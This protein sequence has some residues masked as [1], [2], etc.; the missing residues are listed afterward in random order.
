M[1]H[2]VHPARAAMVLR[3]AEEQGRWDDR[4]LNQSEREALNPKGQMFGGPEALKT[5]CQAV[6]NGLTE[7]QLTIAKL[8]AGI[9]IATDELSAWLTD[10][11]EETFEEE[12]EIDSI[13]DIL[14]DTFH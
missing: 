10:N 4:W 8:Q 5:A 9:L 14:I 3:L 2:P 1:T 6:L 13:R 11:T 12:P 7:D